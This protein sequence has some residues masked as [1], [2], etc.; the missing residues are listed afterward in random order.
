MPLLTGTG[1][2]KRDGYFFYRGAQLF[3]AR[4]GKWKAH[5][6]TQAGYGVPKP[7][8]HDPPLLF[9]V[10]TD[11]GENVNV[12]AKHPEVLAEIAAAVARHRATVHAAPTQLEATTGAAAQKAR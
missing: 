12:A 4:V 6:F 5:Y 1:V 8:A 3:A 11:P 10:Q 9:D 2:V 7:E